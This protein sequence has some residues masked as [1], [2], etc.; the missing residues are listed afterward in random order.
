MSPEDK[1]R[2]ELT[3]IANSMTARQLHQ[4]VEFASSLTEQMHEEDLSTPF[5]DPKSIPR[6]KELIGTEVEKTAKIYTL[7]KEVSGLDSKPTQ[8]NQKRLSNV[9][10]RRYYR[11]KAFDPGQLQN[12]FK[13]L[14]GFYEEDLLGAGAFSERFKISLEENGIKHTRQLP[15]EDIS[16]ICEISTSLS[17][18]MGFGSNYMSISKVKEFFSIYWLINPEDITEANRV[19]EL[20]EMILELDRVLEGEV[21]Y[22]ER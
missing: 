17:V 20:V 8:K 9:E 22:S 21:Y 4:V 6:E 5:L 7:D 2:H 19:T 16:S 14:I 3:I 15:F 1:L 12:L 18:S 11:F 10:I 13:Q